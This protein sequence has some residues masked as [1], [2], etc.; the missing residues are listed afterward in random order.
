ME[1]IGFSDGGVLVFFQSC[2]LGGCCC[3]EAN[4]FYSL[5]LPFINSSAPVDFKTL[6]TCRLP[7]FPSTHSSGVLL[8]V[9]VARKQCPQILTT[10]RDCIYA[11]IEAN[12]RCGDQNIQGIGS[13]ALKISEI[14]KRPTPHHRINAA[15]LFKSQQVDEVQCKQDSIWT[16]PEVGSCIQ[17]FRTSI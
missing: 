2:N 14:E 5:R 9:V 1:D 7:K 6:S 12:P 11:P 3:F 10:M 8:C 17:C 16:F 15:F 4:F 13:Q